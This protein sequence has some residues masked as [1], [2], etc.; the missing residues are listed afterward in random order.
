MRRWIRTGTV[1][2]LTLIYLLGPALWE[3]IGA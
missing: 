2:L 3:P 1:I